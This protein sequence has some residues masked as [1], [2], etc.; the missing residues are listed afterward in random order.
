MRLTEAV[1]LSAFASLHD[2]IS[3]AYYDRCERAEG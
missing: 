3:R 2:P 1:G